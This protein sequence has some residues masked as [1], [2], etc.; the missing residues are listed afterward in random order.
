MRE[1]RADDGG[2]IAQLERGGRR[3]L[4]LGLGLGFGVRGRPRALGRLW[5]CNGV[6][7]VMLYLCAECNR[8]WCGSSWKQKLERQFEKMTKVKPGSDEGCGGCLLIIVIIAV[9]TIF[10]FGWQDD[11]IEFIRNLWGN[12]GSMLGWSLANWYWI[13]IGFFALL[14]LLGVWGHYLE[15]QEKKQA[16]AKSGADLERNGELPADEGIAP[17]KTKRKAKSK[18]S[19]PADPRGRNLEDL[20][21]DQ[22]RGNL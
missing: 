9:V 2:D 18:V 1:V 5:E 6:G 12:I 10:V 11:V 14:V 3:V 15:E 17:Q 19:S 20:F 16:A 21:S 7:V 4:Q 8:R 22:E 13:L